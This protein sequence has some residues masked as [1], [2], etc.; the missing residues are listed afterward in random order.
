MKNVVRKKI[1]LLRFFWRLNFIKWYETNEI[2]KWNLTNSA[3][4]NEL[5]TKLNTYVL[6][7]NRPLIVNKQLI[8]HTQEQ[9]KRAKIF[10]INYQFRL[11][12]VVAWNLSKKESQQLGGLKIQVLEEKTTNFETLPRN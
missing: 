4:K 7:Q 2:L 12:K 5:T 11:W 8:V 3:L 1:K 9:T 6:R 10:Y